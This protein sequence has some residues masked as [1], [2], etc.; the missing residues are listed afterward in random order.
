[1]P[2]LRHLFTLSYNYCQGLSR[3]IPESYKD[4]GR[5]ER[6]LGWDRDGGTLSNPTG[7]LGNSLIELIQV[8]SLPSCTHPRKVQEDR[9]SAVP[10]VDTSSGSEAGNILLLLLKQKS[11][12]LRREINA[13]EI[14]AF[15]HVP[16]LLSETDLN[17]QGVQDRWGK[18]RLQ[19][20]WK[21][22]R[23]SAQHTTTLNPTINSLLCL[24]TLSFLEFTFRFTE[25][26][27]RESSCIPSFSYS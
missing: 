25:L 8:F 11:F 12:K 18:S 4:K 21:I 5:K 20:R 14:P 24:N 9:V 2:W 6:H 3:V 23:I 13:C 22:L 26:L 27:W 7:F 1:M 16:F 19:Q 10:A 15:R 17:S